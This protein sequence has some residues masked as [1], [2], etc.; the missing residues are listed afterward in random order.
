[1]KILLTL[2]CLL[3][4][5]TGRLWAQNAGDFGA[6]LILG[7]PTGATAKLW[8]DGSHAL[9]AGLGFDSDVLIYGDYLWHSLRV[10]PQPTEGKLPVYLG[11]GAQI[12]DSQH[13]NNFG[14]RAVAGVAYL[15][16]RNPLEIFFELVP[17]LHFSHDDHHYHDNRTDLNAGL[18]LRYYFT[19]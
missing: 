14:L 18:G 6:G 15:F 10:F 5:G 2:V 7:N 4:A 13:D 19:W 9:D 12:G 8:L 17:V 16:P 3:T 11:L 1:M